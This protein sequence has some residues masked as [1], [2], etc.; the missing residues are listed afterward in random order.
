V[1]GRTEFKHPNVPLPPTSRFLPTSAIFLNRSE[2]RTCLS[3]EKSGHHKKQDSERFGK[4]PT[5][6][7]PGWLADL[8]ETQTVWL[9]P[10][11][12]GNAYEAHDVPGSVLTRIM[13]SCIIWH[14]TKPFGFPALCGIL[15]TVFTATVA[16]D[17]PIVVTV[18]SPRLHN[19]LKLKSQQP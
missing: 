17:M 8:N 11:R 14:G 15:K 12:A 7:P 5:S 6:Q 1:C 10:H 4:L 9:S 3:P 2:W 13:P 19:L 16:V 18:T